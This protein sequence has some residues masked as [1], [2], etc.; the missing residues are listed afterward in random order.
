MIRV[1]LNALLR[2]KVLL[3]ENMVFP[4]I[5]PQNCPKPALVY[6]LVSSRDKA[7]IS[8]WC[9][10]SK[11][12][13]MMQ[14]DVYDAS[15]A[16]VVAVANEVKTALKTWKHNIYEIVERERFEDNTELYAISIEFKV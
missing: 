2:E 16:V 11:E 9:E 14:I 8:G 12:K 5:M 10:G 7:N 4:K 6:G 1:D 15:Y 3:V 13:A